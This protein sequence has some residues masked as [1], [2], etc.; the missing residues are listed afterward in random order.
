MAFKEVVVLGC[1][2]TPQGIVSGG[3]L[4]ITSVP[5]IKN[6]SETKG[7]YSGTLQFTVA[8]ANAVGY[9]PGTV[10][11]VGPATI[12]PTALKVLVDGSL[13]LRKDD[14]VLAA[15]MTGT[16]LAVPTPFTEP[17]KITNAGQTKVVA[18]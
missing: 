18:Q 2:I 10:V 3:V 15:A 5:S 9:D 13:V 17:F 1:T 16:I 7:M 6:F 8:G 11:T 12:L 4:V 14:Q